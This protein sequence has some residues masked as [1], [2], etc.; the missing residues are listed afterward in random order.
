MRSS[1][2]LALSACTEAHFHLNYPSWRGDSFAVDRSQWIWPCTS[3]TLLKYPRK[4]TDLV[5]ANV[6]QENSSSDRTV[7]PT[8]GGSLVYT[9][10][11]AWVYAFANLGLGDVVTGF[12]ISLLSSFNQTGNGTICLPDIGSAEL[13]GI[14]ITDGQTASIQ[15]VTVN[16]EGNALY[17][18]SNSLSDYIT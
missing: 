14:N 1:L 4:H 18:V 6:S 15:V 3:P 16:A 7:W 12:N 11:H 13:A 5:G 8:S 10:S 17:N 9:S 2:L